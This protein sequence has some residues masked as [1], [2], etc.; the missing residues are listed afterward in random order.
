MIQIPIT[1]TLMRIIDHPTPLLYPFSY[2]VCPP[3]HVLIEHII[4]ILQRSLLLFPLRLFIEDELF[5]NGCLCG[6]WIEFE[7]F[8]PEGSFDYLCEVIRV[9]SN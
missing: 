4:P 7:V 3:T 5:Q 1:L 8:A 6:F 9:H 2:I